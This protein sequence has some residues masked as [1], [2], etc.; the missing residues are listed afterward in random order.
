MQ[1]NGLWLSTAALTMAL[2]AFQVDAESNKALPSGASFGSVMIISGGSDLDEAAEFRQASPRYPLSVVFTVRG[3][4][5]TVP[6]SFKLL[7]DGN[8]VATMPSAGPWVLIDLPPG[9]YKLQAES[10]GRTVE[11]NVR[12]G[13]GNGQTVYWTLPT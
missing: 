4:D 12:V 2:T 6:D 8:V 3:G 5:Y 7:H 10:G 13:K 11:R 1:R 9:S